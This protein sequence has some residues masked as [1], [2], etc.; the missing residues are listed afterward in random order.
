MKSEK[1]A[2][3]ISNTK[4]K[5][6]ESITTLIGQSN[7][8]ELTEDQ[9]VFFTEDGEIKINAV[10]D[11]E[12]HCIKMGARTG[13]NIEINLHNLSTETLLEV[14]HAVEFQIECNQ[15]ALACIIMLNLTNTFLN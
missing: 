6:V 1:L 11:S 3:T 8:L 2:L 13:S 12:V 7:T 5:L 14:L 15:T 10:T 9:P 4:S